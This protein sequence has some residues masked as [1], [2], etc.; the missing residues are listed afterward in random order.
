MKTHSWIIAALGSL[1][2]ALA[3]R[4][5]LMEGWMARYVP[6][7]PAANAAQATT[8]VLS[9]A[10]L[11]LASAALTAR[12]SGA[13]SWAGAAG[14]GALAGLL[15]GGLTFALYGAPAAGAAG[16]RPVYPFIVTPAQ[17]DALVELIKAVL[18]CATWT[19]GL[20][21]AMGLGGGLGQM[22]AQAAVKAHYTPAVSPDFPWYAAVGF[23]LAVLI[24]LLLGAWLHGRRRSA[25]A[26]EAR[27]VAQTSYTLGILAILLRITNYEFSER[28]ERNQPP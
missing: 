16:T 22:I 1:A 26:A 4:Y 20:G 11:L 9:G 8:G 28:I 12:L 19:Y 14:A 18:G 15:A 6:G 10:V 3:L 21:W 27:S 17:T 7:A 5:P 13:R 25:D 23:P 24:A 2:T